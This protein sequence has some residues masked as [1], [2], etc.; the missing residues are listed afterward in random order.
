MQNICTANTFLNENLRFNFS[1]TLQLPLH[2]TN[3]SQ[4]IYVTTV[5][6]SNPK[7]RSDK[8]N[9]REEREEKREKIEKREK[10]EKREK[11]REKRE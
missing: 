6:G 2:W 8:R 7:V 11:K 10:R 9:Q 3:F 1:N 5:V 4:S